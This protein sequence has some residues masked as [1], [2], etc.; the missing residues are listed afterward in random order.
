MELMSA[1]NLLVLPSLCFET[2]PVTIL[3]ASL[4]AVPSMVSGHG[5]LAELVRDGVT[6]FHFRSGDVEDLAEKLVSSLADSAR[7][8]EMGRCAAESIRKGDSGP[9]RNVKRLVDIYRLSV[10]TGA[11]PVLGARITR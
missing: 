8:A 9:G 3:E 7:L 1:C 4:C 2:F 10:S 6:G 11:G 5:A